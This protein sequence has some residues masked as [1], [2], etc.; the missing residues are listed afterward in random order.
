LLCVARLIK[1]KGQHHLIEAVYRLTC[2]GLNIELA[3]VGEGDAKPF[4]QN[5]AK[6]LGIEARVHFKG[7]IARDIIAKEYA[8]AHV[9]VLPSYKEGMSV[10]GLEAMASG[11]ALIITRSGG[12]GNLVE[13]SKNGYLYDWGDIDGLTENIRNLAQTNDLV[14]QMRRASRARSERFS[15]NSSAE[16]YLSLLEHYN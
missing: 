5:L 14:N 1:H 13:E 3:L 2:D 4:Y 10:A 15:W 12:A 7:Y 6:K 8:S 16:L 11:L 9:F